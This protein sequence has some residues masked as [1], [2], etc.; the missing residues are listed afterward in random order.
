[1]NSVADF[2]K[3]ASNRSGFYRERFEEKKIPT[4]HSNLVILPFFGDL[5]SMCI[6]SS[7]LLQRYR[8]EF[9][10]SKYFILASW[11]GFEGLFPYVDEYWSLTDEAHIKK[12]YEQSDGLKNKSDLNTI[13]Q[14]NLNEFFRDVIST[15]EVEKFYHNGLTEQFFEDFIHPKR[16]LP[17]IPSASVLGKEVNRELM[18]KPGYKVLIHP[19]LFGKQWIN[20]RSKNVPAKKEFWI[21][22]VNYLLEMN[23]SP[24]IWQNY[25]SY[26]LS[27]ELVGKCIFVGEK[28]IIR[29]L[30][31]MRATGCV[32][33]VFNN[34]SRLAI[35][36][37]CPF[38]AVDERSRYVNQREHEIDD[39]CGKD[40]LKQ[41]IYTFSTII[42]EGDVDN[43][44][45]DIFPA[46]VKKLE[47]FLPSIN[48]DELPSTVE[49]NEVLPY[50]KHVR[51]NKPKKL[52]VHFIKVQ[53]D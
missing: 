24:V 48:R 25:L 14:R 7:L 21:E 26:D 13:Y 41:Y 11:P 40:I 3:R 1:M 31:T 10:N 44:R 23:F 16:F 20:G 43:W 12:F 47:N 19:S 42:T 35:L 39:L 30:A 46:I 18:T 6:M 27:Q 32:L 5:R 45:Q 53:R 33:D 51:I 36:S 9:K 2:L 28:E 22:L 4:D 34:T 8:E 38:L 15:T 49:S 50:K 17:F 52:G 29:V 37:R